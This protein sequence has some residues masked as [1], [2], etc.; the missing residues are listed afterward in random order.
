M[1]GTSVRTRPAARIVAVAGS[2]V[3]VLFL[4]TVA[5]TPGSP[6]QPV[7][8]DGAKPSGPFRWLAGAVGLDSLSAGAVAVVAVFAVAFAAVA[9]VCVLREAWQGGLSP[10]F[11]IGLAIAYE[12]VVLLLPLLFSRDVYSYAYYGRIA[13]VY[14]RNPYVATPAD[15]PGDALA[16]FVGPKWVDTPAVYGPAFTLLSSVL[17]R[18]VHDIPALIVAFRCIAVGAALGTIAIVAGLTRRVW[19]EREAFAV[20]AIGLNP[21]VLFQ[22]VGSGHNDLLVALAV[23]GALAFVF[24]RRA[25]LGTAALTLGMLVK[26]TAAVPLLLLVVA[27]VARAEPGRRLRT[28]ALHIAV[29][30]GIALAFAAPFMQREDPTLGM[31]ELAQHEGWLA[32]SRL[33]ARALNAVS[34]DTLGIVVRIAFPLALLLVVFLLARRLWQD[35]Q[36]GGPSAVAQGAAWGWGLLFLMLLGPVLLPWYV[37]WALPLVWLLPRAPRDALIGTGVALA[38][39]QFSTEPDRFPAAFDANLFVGHYVITPVVIG[40]L[41]WAAVDLVRRLR[42]G[43][44]LEDVPGEVAAGSGER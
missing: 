17:T 7:L 44:P 9:F 27:A 1:E 37:T 38:V 15:F 42:S 19:P 25:P 18:W 33:F 43:A 29:A 26:A 21:V 14:G 11:V 40:L 35:G 34:G 31:V 36:R 10:R 2:V 28:L 24:A 16:A 8:P 22:S 13:G 12:L 39:S 23:A 3:S 4:A 5:A 20:A 32:P 6:F 41:V 30:G